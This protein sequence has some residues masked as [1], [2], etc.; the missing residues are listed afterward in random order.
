MYHGVVPF[1]KTFGDVKEGAI[2]G[3][4]NSLMNFSLAI[5]MG[6]FSDSFNIKTGKDWDIHLKSPT[7][8]EGH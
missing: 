5:N 4:L 3:Y 8:K 1:V 7:S 6:N 2:M